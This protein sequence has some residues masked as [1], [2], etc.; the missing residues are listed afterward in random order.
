MT[1][2]QF[3]R[4][5]YPWIV[6]GLRLDCAWIATLSLAPSLVEYQASARTCEALAVVR[7]NT[8]IPGP[9]SLWLDATGSRLP[10]FLYPGCDTLATLKHVC[11]TGHDYT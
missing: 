3:V 7:R 5:V 6:L 4:L 9:S 11:A 10:P 2:G 1:G 8:R